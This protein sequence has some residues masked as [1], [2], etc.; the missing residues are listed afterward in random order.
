MAKT[1]VQT[2]PIS[3]MSM[4]GFRQSV[5]G[6]SFRKASGVDFHTFTARP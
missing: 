6:F 4:T 2:A 5:A 3:T 1:V